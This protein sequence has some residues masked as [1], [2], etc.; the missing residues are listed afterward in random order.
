[1]VGTVEVDHD[2]LLPVFQSLPAPVQVA[3]CAHAVRGPMHA[4]AAK[5]AMTT[6][7]R[8]PWS[9]LRLLI[10]KPTPVASNERRSAVGSRRYQPKCSS[11]T[12]IKDRGIDAHDPIF[13]LL[14]SILLKATDVTIAYSAYAS[15]T[16]SGDT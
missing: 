4:P 13:A 2:Q 1:L 8:A 5:N 3:S 14:Y 16:R 10:W 7:S 9:Q 12:H 15:I 11:R 6:H